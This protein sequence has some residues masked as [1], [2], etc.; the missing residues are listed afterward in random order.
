MD[1][2][3]II[4]SRDE[5]GATAASGSSGWL[6]RLCRRQVLARLGRIRQGRLMVSDPLGRMDFGPDE[7]HGTQLQVRDLRA[8]VDIAARGTIGAAEAYM[9]GR[10]T[11]P[12]LTALV[13]LMVANRHALQGIEAGLARAAT[14]LQRLSHWFRRN[15]RRQARRN[16]G[17]HYD[18]GN[19]FYALFLDPTMSYSAGIF[20]TPA[21]SLEEASVHKLD[22]ICRKLALGPGD[23]LLEIG[24]GWGGLALHAARRFGCR[25]TTTTISRRQ[26][27]FAQ[28]RIHAAGLAG[29]V[30]VLDRDYRDLEGQFDKLVSVEMIEAVGLGFLDD[31]FRL[32]SERL[33]PGGL[34]LLQGIVIADQLYEQAR[35]SVDF[36]QKYIFPGGALPSLGAIRAAVARSTDLR[37]LGLEDIGEHYARTLREW[38]ARFMAQLPAV[39]RLGYGED[40][41]RMWE[42][43]LAYCEGGFLERSISDVQ[44]LLGKPGGP[45]PAV[46]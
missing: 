6:A 38:R 8:Y 36:I 12:D 42:F 18:L 29:R 1:R 11:T 22:V 2:H 39:R 21:S 35:R 45:L 31:Y 40:F 30:T 33:R 37:A 26:H 4:S 15:T 27:E 16:I 32:C 19:D 17:A 41:I 5:A 23:H 43:Y 34:M 9:Q 13:R 46:A 28:A 25:V 7:G 14:P 20:P 44:L 24:T 10:W 3:H